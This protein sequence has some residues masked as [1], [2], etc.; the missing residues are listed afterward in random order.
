MANELV[1]DSPEPDCTMDYY[2]P[3]HGEGYHDLP[4]LP[5]AEDYMDEDPF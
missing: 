1:N 3:M 5:W 4:D 2:C